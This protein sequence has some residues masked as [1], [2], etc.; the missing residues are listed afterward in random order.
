MDLVLL[1][2]EPRS[3]HASGSETRLKQGRGIS[4]K[5]TDVAQRKL[6]AMGVSSRKD[7]AVG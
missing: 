2:L 4:A 7:E 3:N 1:C 5:M 6:W